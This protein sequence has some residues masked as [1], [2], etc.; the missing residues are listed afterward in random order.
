M[1]V[2]DSDSEKLINSLIREN[3][4]NE[5]RYASAFVRDKIQL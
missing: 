5:D 3:F 2:S 4:I 1:G